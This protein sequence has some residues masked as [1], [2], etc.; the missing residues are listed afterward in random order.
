[1]KFENTL[2]FKVIVILLVC[3]ISVAAAV[4]YA[5]YRINKSEMVEELE[6]QASQT[7]ERLSFGLA[8]PMWEYLDVQVGEIISLEMRNEIVASIV[9]REKNGKFYR[10]MTKDK[11][12]SI[13][14]MSPGEMQSVFFMKVS[15]EII[16]GSVAL[17]NVE[18]YLTDAQLKQAIMK[19]INFTV[20]EACILSVVI[21]LAVYISF[22]RIIVNPLQRVMETVAGVADG[23][24]DVPVMKSMTN[25]EIGLFMKAIERM[26]G[27]L[28][29]AEVKRAAAVAEREKV[30]QELAGKT[31]EMENVV[32]IT[33]HDLRSPL[34]NI[35]GFSQCL[36]EQCSE[37]SAIVL[38]ASSGEDVGKTAAPILNDKIPHY[39]GFITAGVKKIETLLGGLLKLSRTGRAVLSLEVI[40]A[41]RMLENIATSMMFQL[42]NA[43][44]S[45]EVGE[46]PKCFGDINQINQVFS[47]LI[48][49]AI[50]YRDPVRPLTVRVSGRVEKGETIYVVEDN[51][52]GI[53]RENL[54]KVWE[55]FQRLNPRGPVGGEGLGL[56]L[57]KKIVSRHKGRAWIESE[58][59]TGS[60]FFVALPIGPE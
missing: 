14:E 43:G 11:T 12:G 5:S 32:Y 22:S 1:M 41:G 40:D 36:A 20:T 47:N 45:I 9:I 35:Q 30:M 60:R 3:T 7:V 2:S 6:R 24:L 16:K 42:Q 46:L 55:L 33:S 58:H 27:N 10:G 25:D 4:G 34:I 19:L 53:S 59:G 13:R 54:E 8:W 38:K 56:T 29:T 49:N 44:A 52:I 26:V 50:K 23:N 21:I 18:L 15:R 17:G 57:V 37:L 39:I 31:R 28:R 48:D 51:G